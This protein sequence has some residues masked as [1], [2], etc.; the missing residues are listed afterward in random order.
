MATTNECDRKEEVREGH[1]RTKITLME[2]GLG[3][4]PGGQT[5]D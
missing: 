3:W 2:R 1:G 4:F 5:G